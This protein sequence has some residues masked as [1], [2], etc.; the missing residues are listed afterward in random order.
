VWA[1]FIPHPLIGFLDGLQSFS[2]RRQP[3]RL[4]TTVALLTSGP[5]AHPEVT[6]APLTHRSVSRE[7]AQTPS[8]ERCSDA[9][10]DT[11][12]H[13]LTPCRAATLLTFFPSEAS[14]SSRWLSPP[15]MRFA[16]T[17]TAETC[18]CVRGHYRV[19]IRATL[20]VSAG[21]E[22]PASMGFFTSCNHIRPPASRPTN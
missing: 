3:H 11:L 13:G 18:G 2:H 22:T 4:S 10:S 17:S 19:S 1:C 9:V 6:L 20:G 16:S 12:Q 15:L 21:A 8:S 14:R 5:N 7:D